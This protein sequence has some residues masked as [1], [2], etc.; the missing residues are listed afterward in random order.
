MGICNKCAGILAPLVLG[1]AILRPGD[2]E[3]FDR[4]TQMTGILKQEQLDLIIQ[5]VI[6]PYICMGVV[7]ILLGI[8]IRYSSLPELSGFADQP[9]EPAQNQALT[10]AGRSILQYP[11]L[12]LGAVAIFFHVGAQVVAIDTIIG[13]ARS[14]G[15]SLME[16]KVFP[17]YTLFATICGY[18]AGIA[19]IPKIITQLNMLRLCTLLGLVLSF[20]VLLLDKEILLL[21]H[22]TNISVWMLVGMGLAN[23]MIWAGI[24]PLALD[25][26]G[27]Q[28]KLGASVLI[29]ALSGNAIVPVFYGLLA[30]HLGLRYAYLV[31]IP[32][33]LY[34]V[35]YAYKGYRINRWSLRPVAGHH[36]NEKDASNS[37]SIL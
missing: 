5:R 13:Y 24:W 26:L 14:T 17:S 16:A 3:L 4:I 21:G 20:L 8:F 32:C 36:Q 27:D 12:I 35:Y 11:H 25:R 30:D 19:L 1:A 37:K 34:L 7:L 23:S 28:L 6:P 31:L 9:E 10:T 22:R 33:Y 15:M 29:M 18:L 2:H